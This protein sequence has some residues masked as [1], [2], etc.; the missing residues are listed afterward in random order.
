MFESSRQST[1]ARLAAEGI[2]RVTENNPTTVD[3]IVTAIKAIAV[4]G[5]T[6]TQAE[7]RTLLDS[8]GVKVENKNTIGAAFNR[9][10]RA[11]LITIVGY[12]NST[13]PSAHSRLVRE[14][15]STDRVRTAA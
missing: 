15:I 6:F 14:W 4:T 2:E 3:Q 8:C 10:A 1:G 13:T 9:A 7:V 11:G 5:K 12:K